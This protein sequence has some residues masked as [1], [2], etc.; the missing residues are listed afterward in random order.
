GELFSDEGDWFFTMEL[1]DGV[2][3][4]DYVRPGLARSYDASSA[5]T[6]VTLPP[7]MESGARTMRVSAGSLLNEA[8]L[9]TAL[10]QLALGLHALHEANKVH[11]DIKPSNI[12]V[13][14]RGRVVL[15]DFG[16]ATE[17]EGREHKSEVDIVGTVEYMAPE[18]AAARQVGPPADWYSIG[19]VLF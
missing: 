8:R 17:L 12:L 15:L 1:L 7:V 13:T 9:R 18:Q 10:R 2:D 11:R 16:L 3:F 14:E 19:V 6:I 5:D 4:F